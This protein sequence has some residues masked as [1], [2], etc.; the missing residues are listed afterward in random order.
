M[1]WVCARLSWDV[2]DWT[3]TFCSCHEHWGT[4]RSSVSTWSQEHSLV[5]LHRFCPTSTTLAVLKRY[6]QALDIFL[7]L[8]TVE[9]KQSAPQCCVFEKENYRLAVWR[10]SDWAVLVWAKLDL[11]GMSWAE[12]NWA[13][14]NEAGL[15][16]CGVDWDEMNWE[17]WWLWCDN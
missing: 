4:E 8:A 15:V 6:F 17:C 11:V 5:L 3:K 14:P 12:I 10:L 16:W 2:Q 13:R 9:R 7:H 1:V